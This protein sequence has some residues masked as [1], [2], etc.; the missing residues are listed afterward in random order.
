MV[1]ELILC[2]M[3]EQLVLLRLLYN[4]KEWQ[5]G[6]PLYFHVKTRTFAIIVPTTYRNVLDC[7]LCFAHK[8]SSKI[9]R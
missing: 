1:L 7:E 9:I 6:F 2:V 4:S 3:Q 5:T 8:M